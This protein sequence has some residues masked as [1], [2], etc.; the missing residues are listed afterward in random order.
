MPEA[1]FGKVAGI[2]DISAVEDHRLGKQGLD[3]L[4]VRTP[5]SLPLGDNHQRVGAFQRLVRVVDK[6]VPRA[7]TVRYVLLACS[8]CQ[9]A[10][11]RVLAT[12]S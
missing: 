4:E 2:V 1:H 8:E 10:R 11:E 5:E 3:A 9:E 12:V 6:A 7:G